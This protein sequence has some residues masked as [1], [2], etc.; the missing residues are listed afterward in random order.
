MTLFVNNLTNID[1]S[2][3]SP[4][5][6]LSGASWHVDVEL[7]GELGGFGHARES[8]DTRPRKRAAPSG[9]APYATLDPLRAQ[10]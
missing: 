9:A 8:P 5:R 10:A 1:A 2:I 7:D 4:Q 3:W 6:G